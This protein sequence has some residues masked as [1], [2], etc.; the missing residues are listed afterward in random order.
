MRSIMGFLH[1]HK[2]WYL[3]IIVILVHFYRKSAP[4]IAIR[5]NDVIPNLYRVRESVP[6]VGMEVLLTAWRIKP[7]GCLHKFR[8]GEFITKNLNTMLVC[9]CY[10]YLSFI[11]G[12]TV[13]TYRV[14][15]C[16]K[17]F[18]STGQYISHSFGSA[19][20]NPVQSIII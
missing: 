8:V 15:N 3:G 10:K 6:Y 7:T 20:C 14:L 4:N 11:V 5:K 9:M 2:V 13:Y 1:F 16:M 12:R 19:E 18:T 17:G